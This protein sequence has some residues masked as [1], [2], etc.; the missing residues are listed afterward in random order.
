MIN[1]LEKRK[2][3]HLLASE[4]RQLKKL[5]N[6]KHGEKLKAGE[7]LLEDNVPLLTAQVAKAEVA[8]CSFKL[9]LHLPQSRSIWILPV[10]ELILEN[11]KIKCAVKEVLTDDGV[12]F[13]RNGTEMAEHHWTKFIYVKG[14]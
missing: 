6:S 3:K 5:I 9:P 1:S 14:D 8:Y 2:K 13:F 11:S 7:L 12:T 10:S 4:L